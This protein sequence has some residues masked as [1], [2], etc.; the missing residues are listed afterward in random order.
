MTINHYL[1]I[2]S[3]IGNNLFLGELLCQVDKLFLLVAQVEV[4]ARTS[5][6]TRCQTPLDGR[7]C[8][9]WELVEVSTKG[10][11]LDYRPWPDLMQSYKLN[12]IRS[13]S[14]RKAN[15]GVKYKNPVNFKC[16]FRHISSKKLGCFVKYL[17]FFSV[18]DKLA[19]F[20]ELKCLH[21]IMKLTDFVTTDIND[22]T[23]MEST[24]I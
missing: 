6:C 17:N 9:S 13:K 18:Y 5:R 19:S 3:S 11:H 4:E 16:I 21:F 24:D 10:C 1:V 12:E 23:N 20:L 7:R 14:E 8:K 22:L 2:V 15:L